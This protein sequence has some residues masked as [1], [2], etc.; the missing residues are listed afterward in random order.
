MPGVASRARVH[1]AFAIMGRGE[2]EVLLLNSVAEYFSGHPRLALIVRQMC[3][4][5]AH[6]LH[7]R[8]VSQ[9]IKFVLGEIGH[10]K[11]NAG[12]AL[13]R[14]CWIRHAGFACLTFLV[15]YAGFPAPSHARMLRFSSATFRRPCRA[16][17]LRLVR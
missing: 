7:E 14:C 11:K 15:S 2:I 9:R 16:G 13:G 12:N 4:S 8:L 3:S 17:A 1:Q 6:A 5:S 10:N